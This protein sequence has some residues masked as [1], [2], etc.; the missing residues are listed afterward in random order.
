MYR[1][2]YRPPLR[3]YDQ[4][5]GFF[6]GNLKSPVTVF[7]LLIAGSAAS[8]TQWVSPGSGIY[9][10]P[11]NWSAG[12]PNAG[13]DAILDQDLT[14]TI[15]LPSEFTWRVGNLYADDGN[16]TLDMG[17]TTYQVQGE[18]GPGL[19]VGRIPGQH[20]EITLTNGR[21][22]TRYL[23]GGYS[24]TY[25]GNG[26]GTSGS[27]TIAGSSTQF[28]GSGIGYPCSGSNVQYAG[29][30]GGTGTI[31][32]LDGADFRSSVYLGYGTGSTGTL[33]VDGS[34]TTLNGTNV[35]LGSGSSNS[36]SSATGFGDGFLYVRNGAVIGTYDDVWVRIGT[37]F[38]DG[39]TGHAEVSGAGSRIFGSVSIDSSNVGSSL[40]IFDNGSV[41]SYWVVLHAD[42]SGN[43]N[44]LSVYDGGQLEFSRLHIEEL[45]SLNIN[46]GAQVLG[47][48]PEQGLYAGQDYWLGGLTIC[49]GGAL[50]LAGGTLRANAI[51]LSYALATPSYTDYYLR[52]CTFGVGTPPVFN[53]TAGTLTVTQFFGDLVATGGTVDPGD[54]IGTTAVT[55]DYVQSATTSLR[56]N[57]D[58]TTPGTGHDQVTVTGNA[59]LDGKVDVILDPALAVSA[60][61]SFDILTANIISGGFT[62]IGHTCISD[63][64]YWTVTYDINP[65]GTDTASLTVAQAPSGTVCSGGVTV[66]GMDVDPWTAANEVRPDSTDSIVIAVLGSNT[67]SGDPINFDVQQIDQNTLRF[68]PNGAEIISLEPLFGDYDADSNQDAAFVFTTPDTGIACGDTD[69]T[70]TGATYAGEL[71]EGTSPIVTTDCT[72]ECHP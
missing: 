46:S 42:T 5:R 27:L 11:A 34:G 38:G 48:F 39:G 61:D 13:T 9:N 18:N 58:G 66:V 35:F 59:T 52:I 21:F 64:L 55:G 62:A 1:R 53:M 25:T 45:A 12:V 31:N 37:D 69:A 54:T 15:T 26:I 23:T 56:I 20:A 10:D 47:W 30:Y 72:T 7:L 36:G 40:S 32:I 50:N 22:N 19:E 14:Y 17:G 43:G 65:A 57:I 44:S 6:G 51:D 2:G 68:G 41:E 70:V 3:C 8:Q 63:T 33:T 28:C 4:R 49:D 24:S 71:F 16:A 29:L 60:G 67:A